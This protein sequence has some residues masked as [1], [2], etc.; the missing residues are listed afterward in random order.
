MSAQAMAKSRNTPLI[1]HVIHRLGA[2]GM[3]NGLV[4][5]VNHLPGDRFRHAIV[6]LTSSS[7]FERRITAPGVEV[8]EMH[9]R[10]G[11]GV[12]MYPKMQR[13]LRRLKPAVVHT[14]NIGTLD[15][16][17]VAAVSGVAVR[18]HGE[19]GWVASDP[20]G[21]N[22]KYRFLRRLCN[23]LIHGYVAVSADIAR[24]MSTVIGIADDKIQQ[25]YNGV[26]TTKFTP[27]G[28][29]AVLPFDVPREE[30]V[31]LGTVGRIDPIKG[32]DTLLAAIRCVLQSRPELRRTLR[33]IVTG[34]GPLLPA[35]REQAARDGVADVVWLTGARDD[36]A[37]IL[38]QLD[39]FILPSLNEGMSNTIL[40]AMSCGRPVLATRVGG[41]GE[42]VVPG[43]TGEL[44]SAAAPAELAQRIMQYCDDANLRQ[45]QGRAGRERVVSEFS[46]QAMVARYTE[47]YQQFIDSNNNETR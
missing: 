40:E 17:P 6:C 36:I 21:M 38:R 18:I 26:D 31:V 28:A 8:I 37:D 10:P 27:R 29:T 20:A 39:V 9:K 33:L 7:E 41:N 19:H 16:A 12:A 46:L 4:N 11:P 1:A 3:E 25:I 35:L 13:L 44:V 24:W 22:R 15:M 47:L 45:R 2:G 32:Q 30:L 34:D 14:R 23:P 42:L 5:L 43:V